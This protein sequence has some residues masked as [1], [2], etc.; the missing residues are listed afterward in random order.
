[1]DAGK[2]LDGAYGNSCQRSFGSFKTN[3][4]QIS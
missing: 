2:Q 3:T 4:G 1:M